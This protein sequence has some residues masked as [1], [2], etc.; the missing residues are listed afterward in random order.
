VDAVA[1]AGVGELERL[2]LLTADGLEAA[3]HAALAGDRTAARR[4]LRKAAQR[5]SA[6]AA[7]EARVRQ[8]LADCPPRSGNMVFSAMQ[9]IAELGHVGDASDALAWH[10]AT[11]KSAQSVPL[12]LESDVVTLGRAGARRI[13]LLAEG[14]PRPAMD[15]AYRQDGYALRAIVDRRTGHSRDRQTSTGHGRMT[16]GAICGALAEAVLMA[17]RFAARA[18]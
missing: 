6:K 10:A 2:A 5:R 4:V 3:I 12:P 8:R 9:L 17:S 14:L 18:A 1:Y 15:S 11:G 13:R 16:V 7:A